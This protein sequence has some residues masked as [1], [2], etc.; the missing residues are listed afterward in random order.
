MRKKAVIARIAVVV[1][2][3]A[4]TATMSGAS[5]GS[6]AAAATVVGY[7]SDASPLDPGS[8]VRAA[9]VRVGD[10]RDITLEGGRARVTLDIDASVLPLHRD[11]RLKI[12]PVNLLGENYVE[13]D[14]G[15]PAQ[16]FLDQQVV[17][18]EQTDSAVTLQDLFNTFDDPTSTALAA[19]VST[20]GDGMHGNGAEA[21]AAIAA[22]APAMQ[23]TGQLGDV[24]K[25]QNATLGQL[26]DRVQPVAQ[27]LA[28]DNGASLD[29]LVGSTEQT[30]STVARN[31]QAMDATLA[32]LPDTLV[33]ARR[34]LQELNGVAASATPTLQSIRPVTDNLVQISGELRDFADAADPALTSLS[35]VLDRADQLLQQAAPVVAL[36]RAAGPDLRNTA[37]GVRPLG[38]QLLDTHLSDLMDFVKKWALSTNGRDGLSHYFRGMAFVT[39]KTLQDLASSLTQQ[40]TTPAPNAPP[41]P[42]APAPPLPLSLPQILPGMAP[43]SPGATGITPAQEQSL[44]G[45]L[46][47]GS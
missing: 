16:P 14:R 22:L 42:T 7:F 36:L 44:L 28:A 4:A 15:S 32:E 19:V 13:L 6:P 5:P 20:L 9:G 18:V 3:L 34:T 10:V 46:L 30:L 17:P 29:Q 21:A 1:A 41:Q 40:N 8:E 24:L 37:Q 27:A 33:E 26:V 39:P 47:G 45:Q 11:A 35:P 31:K 43:N 23:Q 12:R 2:A 25:A 38:D